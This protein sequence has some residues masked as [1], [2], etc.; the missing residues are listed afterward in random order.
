M[1]ME[2]LAKRKKAR[3]IESFYP[4]EGDLR[5]ELYR[6]HLAFFNAGAVTRERAIIA[7]NRIGKSEGVGGFETSLHLT[8]LYPKWWKGKRF[9]RPVAAWACGSTGQTVRDIVQFKLLGSPGQ[10]GTGMIPGECLGDMKKKAGN[11]PDAIESVMVQHVT[12]GWSRLVF[13]SYDQKRK[14]FEGT[15]QDVIWLDE[16]APMDIY[17][18]CLIR[19]MTT[20]GIIMLTF[21]PLMG[22]TEVVLNYMPNG[23]M[24]TKKRL[25]MP[26]DLIGGYKGTKFI[27][28]ATWDDAPHLNDEDKKDIWAGT[29][30]HLRDARAKGVPQL[31]AGVVYPILQEDIE[32]PDMELPPWF[33][34][35]YALDVGWNATAVLWGAWDRESDILYLYSCY[36]Q[37]MREPSSHVVAIQARGDWIPGV[38]DPSAIGKGQQDGKRMI[39]EYSELGLNLAY[40]NN[41]VEAGIFAVWERMVTGRLKIFKSLTPVFNE[42]R[43]Y[44]R[45]ENGKVA[46]NQEDHLMDCMRY[47][48]LSGL[49]VATQMPFEQQEY[50]YA[51]ERTRTR[52]KRA[53][54]FGIY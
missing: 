4:D 18:E 36:K 30:P 25:G 11:V 48:V 1:G 21:T 33:P 3:K 40:A 27:V 47:L 8:G 19:T 53:G 7:A 49:D 35:A 52:D 29:P 51:D 46:A 24:P 42:H 13:K 28:N 6:P 50:Y 16:E 14:A 9:S 26:A 15:E 5:R 54:Y 31:G 12:G 23:E 32:V 45:D 37:G 22:L 41:A 2:I 39:D 43:I 38:I 34:R 44:R 20:G 10:E 17:G